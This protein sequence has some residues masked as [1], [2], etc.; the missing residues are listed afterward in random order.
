MTRAE[1]ATSKGREREREKRE[2]A[3]WSFFFA[4]CD[5]SSDA[6]PA[7][8]LL[9]FVSLSRAGSSFFSVHAAARGCGRAAGTRA[10]DSRRGE[11]ESSKEREKERE[12][13][14]ERG[15][16]SR[17]NRALMRFFFLKTSALS[18]LFFSVKNP[19]D[20]PRLPRR[21]PQGPP[22]PRRQR[23]GV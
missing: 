5:T 11:S 17:S 19:S 6:F 2:N 23:V 8:H 7:L 1:A 3:L 10:G 18:P 4:S 13:K 16:A 12:N 22:R 15:N 9:S 14:R 21:C 20:P